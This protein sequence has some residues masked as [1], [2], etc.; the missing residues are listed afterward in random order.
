MVCSMIT[1]AQED[2]SCPDANIG[3]SFDHEAAT[4]SRDS[5]AVNHGSRK[6]RPPKVIV[7][8][9]RA[10]LS[11]LEPLVRSEQLLRP[12]TQVSH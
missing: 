5:L 3:L 9:G 6:D 11:L 1:R 10:G 8:L 12:L 2:G 7:T 4:I